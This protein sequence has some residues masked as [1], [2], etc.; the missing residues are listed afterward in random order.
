MN[1]VAARETNYTGGTIMFSISELTVNLIRERILPNLE[2]LNCRAHTLK[3]GA[4]V[5]DMGLEAGGSWEAANLFTQVTLGTLCD[6]SYG[7]YDL[8]GAQVPSVQVTSP[9]PQIACLS[10][11]FSAWKVPP[12]GEYQLAGFASGPAR[13]ITRN[14]KVSLMWPYQ[15]KHPETALALQTAELP[16]ED[17]AQSVAD[18]CGIDPKGVYLLA[19][20]TGSLVGCVQIS[21]RTPEVSMWGLGF[22]GFD[23]AKV[24][25]CTSYAPVPPC[26][27]DELRAMDRVNSSCLYGGVIS[28]VVD[29]EDAELEGL[30]EKLV[31]SNTRHF[32]RRFSDLYE[33]AGRDIFQMDSEVHKVAEVTLNNLNTGTTVSAGKRD[34][35]MLKDSFYR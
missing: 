23:V 21:A 9:N 11:Q 27:R 18:A 34:L 30:A 29:C 32:G 3:N 14:D 28:Y 22:K 13:A 1:E 10:A 7:L 15:D 33:E 20:T 8:D 17:F 6:V 24:I 35:R 5:I 31:F 2:W 4:T 25:A 26:T 12:A 19:A 16:G